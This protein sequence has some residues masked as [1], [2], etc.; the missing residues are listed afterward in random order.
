MR[1]VTT[2]TTMERMTLQFDLDWIAYMISKRCVCGQDDVKPLF[3]IARQFEIDIAKQLA[4]ETDRW[5]VAFNAGAALL[6]DMIKN[7]KEST[8]KALDDAKAN[9]ATVR[10]ASKKGSIELTLTQTGALKPV[11]LQLDPSKDGPKVEEFLGTSWVWEGVDPGHHIVRAQIKGDP[12][13][14]VRLADVPPGGVGRLD[15]KLS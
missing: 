10:A 4:D 2:V 12:N 11:T 5:V 14:I 1:Y 13:E 9:L 7:Q 8:S 3:D 15:L 6:S